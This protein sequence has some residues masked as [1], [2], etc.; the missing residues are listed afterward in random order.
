MGPRMQVD[1][2][3]DPTGRDNFGGESGCPIVTN[4][5]FDVVV[6]KCAK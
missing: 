5:D 1:G 3:R 2:G 6:R 4:G